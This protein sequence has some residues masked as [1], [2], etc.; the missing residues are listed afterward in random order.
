MNKRIIILFFIIPYFSQAQKL[1][2]DLVNQNEFITPGKVQTLVFK[3]TN[4]FP[5]DFLVTVTNTLPEGWVLA[6][7]PYD[8]TLAANETK[9]YLVAIQVPINSSK[10][11]DKINLVIKDKTN[12]IL[13]SQ[14]FVLT[15][16]QLQRITLELI[17]ASSY[18][19]AGDTINNFFMLKNE[20]NV[21]E[22]IFIETSARTFIKG[23]NPILILPGKSVLINAYQ[24]T[25]LEQPKPSQNLIKLTA[26][27]KNDSVQPVFASQITNVIPVFPVNEDVWL[28][29]PIRIAATYIGRQER[30][31]F[32][33]GFQGE[34]YGRGALNE[35]NSKLLEFRAIGPDRFGLTSFSQYE[36]YFINYKSTNFYAHLGD[37]TFS[38]SFLTE[39]SRYGRGVE[40]RQKF[41]KLEVGGFYNKPRFF[42]DIKDEISVYAK[43]NFNAK[44]NIRYGY[45]LK[46]KENNQDDHLH[47][48]AG[49]G[50][51]FK[52]VAVQGE[53][54]LSSNNVAQGNAWQLQTQTYFKDLDVNASYIYAS[55]NFSGYY[56]NTQFF[57]ANINY[58]ILPKLS[59]SSNYQKDARNFERDTLYGAAPYREAFQVGIRY[60]YLKR[61]AISFF[62]GTQEYEDRMEHKQFFYKEMFSRIELS[63]DIYKFSINLQ[64][65]LAETTNFLIN[66]KG[67][68]SLY[69]AN[70]SYNNKGNSISLYGSY[71]TVNRYATKD[72]KLFLYGGRV[73][74]HIYNRWDASLFYQNT[75][76][77]EDYYTDRNLLEL[78]L[79]YRVAPNQ[80]INIL[81]RYALAQHQI[82]NKDFAFSVRYVL[83]INAPIKKIKEYGFFE[84]NITNLGS[85]QIKDIKLHLGPY[86]AITDENGHFL[87]KNVKPDIYFLEIEEGT[88][89][90]QDITDIDIPAKVTIIEGGNY[91]N[92]GITKASGIKGIILLDE[93]DADSKDQ[94]VIVEVIS[95]S[96]VF[97]KICDITK[98]FDFTYLR[99]GDWKLKV[100][101]NGLDS[102]YKIQTDDI[103]LTLNPDEDQQ[104]QVKISK[105]EKEIKYL[106][107]PM[108][109]GFN[110]SKEKK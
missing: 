73:N 39:F 79:N 15:V 19:K 97:R 92:F 106:Q 85:A 16:S 78:A 23:D 11:K 33:S 18:V 70:V 41:N 107:K 44:N 54:A 103:N 86:S 100:Y 82:E 3:I 71:S 43:V 14:D 52:R 6:A 20:G 7:A 101:R 22:N 87:F 110:T 49:E 69:T 102:K 67:A 55:P 38:S 34:I 81:S 62:S 4:P 84:G 31:D 75:Y 76:Y 88:L 105:T 68:S 66:S 48:V 21:K 9:I 40:L 64:M 13:H 91:F 24:S 42:K 80:Q 99:P 10:G 27:V 53:Y 108:R 28:R 93:K 32:D 30:N 63:Q 60:N 17:S 25:E 8:L 12:N 72:E 59:L 1:A 61:G 89:G 57:T 56:T 77:L 35:E 45:L 104:V 46:R 74:A 58:R 83:D 36:E 29:F 65:Y 37:K 26:S 95:D 109:V 94:S 50:N 90:V 96:Q 5:K 51:V 47:Y 98:P 2:V